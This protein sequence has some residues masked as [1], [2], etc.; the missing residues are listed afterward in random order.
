MSSATSP[1]SPNFAQLGGFHS[2]VAANIFAALYVLLSGWFIFGFIRHQTRVTATM[3]IFS[4]ARC[5]AF[6]I[7]ALMIEGQGD[8]SRGLF[9]AVQVL[10]NVGFFAIIGGAFEAIIVAMEKRPDTHRPSLEKLILQ[11]QRIIRL[12]LT[13][14]LAL[15]IVATVKTVEGDL[16]ASTLATISSIIFVIVTV[17]VTFTSWINLQNA[18]SGAQ[19]QMSMLLVGISLLLVA[20]QMFMAVTVSNASVR[21]NEAYWYPF[22][23]IPALFAVSGF[24][25]VGIVKA[26]GKKHEGSKGFGHSEMN[27]R[28][29][30][31]PLT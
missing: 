11:R 25:A 5:A 22:S 17:W 12:V 10:F 31:Q 29:E 27:G 18:H 15:S 9:T 24:A 26:K 3:G 20:R 13:A 19:K 8:T 7:R 23:E 30:Y 2:L 16:G 4:L 1:S 21:L 6:V 28:E 14:A